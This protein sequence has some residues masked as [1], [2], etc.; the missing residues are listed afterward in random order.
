MKRSIMVSRQSDKGRMV[1]PIFFHSFWTP[2]N[3]TLITRRLDSV[4]ER[5]WLKTSKPGYATASVRHFCL[6]PTPSSYPVMLVPG[7]V[8]GLGPVFKRRN[9]VYGLGLGLKGHV[10]GLGLVT[11]VLLTKNTDNFSAKQAARSC[12]RHCAGGLVRSAWHRHPPKNFVSI[13]PTSDWMGEVDSS[14]GPLENTCRWRTLR[15]ANYSP[16]DDEK[17]CTQKGE[18]VTLNIDYW[19]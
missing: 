17:D 6:P 7:L 8:L 14:F 10:L 11:L 12:V 19:W 1:R 2:N 18:I 13:C 9:E 3:Y 16:T 4:G 5:G 15:D